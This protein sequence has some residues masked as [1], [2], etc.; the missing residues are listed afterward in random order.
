YESTVSAAA[1]CRGTGGRSGQQAIFQR[2]AA[3]GFRTRAELQELNCHV[4]LASGVERQLDERV[5]D[6][7]RVFV[8][9]NGA[10]DL[11]VVDIAAQPIGAEQKTVAGL[12]RERRQDIKLYL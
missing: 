1:H 2:R 10:L 6:P 3:R 9:A 12:K 8:V 7:L 5:C 4:V 11:G